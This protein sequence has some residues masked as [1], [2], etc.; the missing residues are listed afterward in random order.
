MSVTVIRVT[1][2][3]SLWGQCY[4]YVKDFRGSKWSHRLEIVGLLLFMIG[5]IPISRSVTDVIVY[6]VYGL[7]W[8]YCIVKFNMSFLKQLHAGLNRLDIGLFDKVVLA[9]IKFGIC[10]M[11]I[12]FTACCYGLLISLYELCCKLSDYMF[13]N[14]MVF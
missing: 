9:G 14:P 7:T 10:L 8:V 12:V 2:Q 13:A 5:L 4:R 6:G 1:K 3:L 11:S